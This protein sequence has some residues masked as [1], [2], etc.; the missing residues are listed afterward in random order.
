MNFKNRLRYIYIKRQG[1]TFLSMNTTDITTDKMQQRALLISL[2]NKYSA[3]VEINAEE[4]KADIELL[5]QIPDKSYICKTLL[6]E[7]K[8]LD[9]AYANFCALFLLEIIDEDTLEKQAIEYLRDKN[10][11]DD[12]KFFIISIM[13]QRGIPIEY[14]QMTLYINQLDKI[15]KNGIKSFLA[16]AID[17]ADSQIDLLD[18]YLNIPK[19]EKLYFLNNLAEEYDGDNLANAFSIIAQLDVDEDEIGIIIEALLNSKSP[20]AIEGLEYILNC[21][22]LKEQT[23]AFISRGLKELRF[24]NLRFINNSLIKNSNVYRCYISFIDGYSNFSLIVSRQKK[25]KELDA[26]LLAINTQKG[27]TSCMG[28]NS[29]SGANFESILKRLFTDSIPI[30]IAPNVLKSIVKYYNQ[31]NIQ[32][33]TTIPYEYIVWKKLLA[34]V[35]ELEEDIS[36]FLNSQLKVIELDDMKVKKFATCKMLETWYYVPTQHPVIDELIEKVE[37]YHINSIEKLNEIVQDTIDTIVLTD[38]SIL[39]ELQTRLLLQ[40]YVAKLAGF[41]ITSSCSYSMCFKNPYRKLL[42]ASIIDKSLYHYFNS[43]LANFNNK[44]KSI[45]CAK[46]KTGFSVTELEGLIEDLESKWL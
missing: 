45:F 16:H 25:N 40:A 7:I 37:K 29:I 23:K 34:D 20:Y 31:K 28:F 30:E 17:E 32:T 22:D 14:S 39:A 38:K 24:S 21:Y 35:Q 11:S 46:Y 4:I 19:E 18:F 44:T 2:L 1:D 9:C 41:T 8:E 27:I 36:D 33:K 6:R 10:I 15:A 43:C 12:K 3:K 5:A 26:M 42:I 13:R